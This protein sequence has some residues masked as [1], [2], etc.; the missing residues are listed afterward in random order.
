MSQLVQMASL[1][2]TCIQTLQLTFVFSTDQQQQSLIWIAQINIL[3][4][5]PYIQA[6]LFREHNLYINHLFTIN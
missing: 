3:L 5:N 2:F 6:T 1:L 4:K